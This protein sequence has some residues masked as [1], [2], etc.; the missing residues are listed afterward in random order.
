MIL[1]KRWCRESRKGSKNV[2]YTY[3]RAAMAKWI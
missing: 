3:S 2:Q 1:I